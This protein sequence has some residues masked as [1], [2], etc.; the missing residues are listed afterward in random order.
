LIE[1]RLVGGKPAVDFAML[2]SVLAIVLVVALSSHVGAETVTY[3]PT[4]AI[5]L[6]MGYVA[7]GEWVEMSGYAWFGPDDGSF[8][9]NQ[10]S[11]MRH[12]PLDLS[13][14][15]REHVRRLQSECPRVPGG[16]AGGCSVLVRGQT[17][18]IGREQGVFVREL[19]RL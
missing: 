8:S 16:M 6:A 5:D 11:T 19:T 14:L 13:R 9:V 17:G 2:N 3:K 1:I 15:D 18:R 10:P 12:A 7:D 4:D